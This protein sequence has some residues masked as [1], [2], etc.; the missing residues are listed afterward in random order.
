MR[1][2]DV[3][4]VLHNLR[5]KEVGEKKSKIFSFRSGDAWY[6]AFQG[7]WNA[8]WEEGKEIEVPEARIQTKTSGDRTF[9]NILAP[10]AAEQKEKQRSEMQSLLTGMR[11]IY[12][13]IMAIKKHL[14]IAP[15]AGK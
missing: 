11:E 9:H 14:G 4:L 6:S 3:K 13:E 2:V 5:E 1:E 8:D 15:G 7:S 12:K 10:P